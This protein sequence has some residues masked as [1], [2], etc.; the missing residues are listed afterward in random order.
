MIRIDL[1]RVRELLRGRAWKSLAV[2]GSPLGG[3]FKARR[4][5]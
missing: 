4:P 1:W 5:A 2:T 3:W